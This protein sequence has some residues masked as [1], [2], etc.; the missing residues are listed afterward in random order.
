MIE[1]AE[2]LVTQWWSLRKKSER[3]GLRIGVATVTNE[4]E[5]VVWFE[6][7]SVLQKGRRS[8]STLLSDQDLEAI[9]RNQQLVG[10]DVGF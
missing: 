8:Y 2:P 3:R 1:I 4:T 5:H 6:Y 10:A 7:F 9:Y